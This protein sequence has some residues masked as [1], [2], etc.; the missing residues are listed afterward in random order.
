MG[1]AVAGDAAFAFGRHQTVG[2]ETHQVLTDRGL[3][4]AESGGELGDVQRAFLERLDDA[5]AVRMGKGA[6][7]AGAVAKDLRV[8]RSGF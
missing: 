1:H 3:G 5:K 7:R 2:A 4:A 6:K 8:K